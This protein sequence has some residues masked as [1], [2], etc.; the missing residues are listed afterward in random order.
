[1]DIDHS[2]THLIDEKSASFYEAPALAAINTQLR[3]G[4]IFALWSSDEKDPEF[5]DAMRS[6]FDSVRVETVEF[7][8]PYQDA[9]TANLIYL[10]RSGKAGE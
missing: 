4:G 9:K 7:Y 3:P 8:N 5:V 1:M 2:T 6:V 10:G